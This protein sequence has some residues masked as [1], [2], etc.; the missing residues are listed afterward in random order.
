MSESEPS[1]AVPNQ[2]ASDRHKKRWWLRPVAFVAVVAIIIAAAAAIRGAGPRRANQYGPLDSRAPAVNQTAPDFVLANTNGQPIRLS[3]LRGKVVLVNFWATWC[4][5]CRQ[6]MPAIAAVYAAH[7][8]QDFTVLEVNE[9]ESPDVVRAF[10]EQIGGV[11]PVVLDRDGSVMR[12]YRLQGLPD[13]FLVDRQGNV[14]ALSYGPIT[15]QTL[16]TYIGSAR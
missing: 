13:S 2:A 11:P 14:H 9:Q 7:R 5:P 1:V 15:Q 10:A 12:Q 4:I 8:G 16:E 6:E 3:D